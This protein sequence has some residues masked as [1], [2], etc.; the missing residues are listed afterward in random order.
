MDKILSYIVTIS[1]LSDVMLSQ[2]LEKCGVTAG[3]YE[4][5]LGCVE[6]KS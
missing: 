5:A 1:G 3:Q 6:K 2:I 4:N